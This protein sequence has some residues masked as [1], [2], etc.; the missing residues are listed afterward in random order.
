M[1]L[2]LSTHFERQSRK[3]G[4]GDEWLVAGRWDFSTWVLGSIGRHAGFCFG[5]ADNTN[6]ITRRCEMRQFND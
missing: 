4:E 6:R 1:T 3:L 5:D 2:D